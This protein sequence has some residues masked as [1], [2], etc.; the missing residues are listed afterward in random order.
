MT[1][2]ELQTLIA[3]IRSQVYTWCGGEAVEQVEKLIRYVE[4]L[5]QN[6]KR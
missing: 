5:Q 6:A 1:D 2:D 3:G 4:V